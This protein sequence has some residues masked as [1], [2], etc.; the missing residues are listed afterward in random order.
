MSSDLFRNQT[1]SNSSPEPLKWVG[2]TSENNN[3]PEWLS[4]IY[5][6]IGPG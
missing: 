3:I 5:L 2:A 4:G 1:D 6:Q